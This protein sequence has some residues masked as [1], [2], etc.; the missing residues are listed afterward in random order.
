MNITS[1]GIILMVP[2]V[3]IAGLCLVIVA[4]LYKLAL[5]TRGSEVIS[6]KNLTRVKRI[7]YIFLAVLL[8]KAGLL[9]ITATIFVHSII[10]ILL[11]LV[12]IIVSSWELLAGMLIIYIVA[13]VF[14]RAVILKEE[15]ALTI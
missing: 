5:S 10:G 6:R 2:Y 15:Q 13:V 11:Q 9:M 7:Q 12:N 8:I 1:I 14:E 3:I 4:N